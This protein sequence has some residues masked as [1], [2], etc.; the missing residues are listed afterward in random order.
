MNTLW[1]TLSTLIAAIFPG[2][3]VQPAPVYNG[4]VEAD[5]VY[6]APSGAGRIETISA[7]EGDKVFQGQMLLKLEDSSQKSALHAA[8]AGVAVAQANLDNL[9]TGSREAEIEVI[10][11]SLHRAEADQHLA[12]TTL[13]RSLVLLGRGLVPPAQVDSE[14]ATLESSNA[15]VEQLRAQLR[16]AELPA[17]DAQQVAAEASLDVAR[18]Q[19]DRARIDLDDRVILAP[20]TGKVE[21]VFF[22]AG[23]VVATGAPVLSIYQPEYLKTIFFIPE[24]ERAGFAI[25]DRLSL[26]CDGCPVG[27]TARITQMASQPQYTPPIIYSR[28]E[29]A[30]LVFRAEAQL[31]DA[32]GLLPGQPVS[33]RRPR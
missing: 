17:R 20:L 8:T 31:S 22:V 5:Y 9:Q 27:L 7:A 10:R 29:R 25:G 28:D 6:V 14:R 19:A 26:T 23:E 33:L 1:Q 3:G 2:F 24:P 15:Q 11:A 4:Y 12:K 16:V 13:D 21:K 32:S 18:A 30:R